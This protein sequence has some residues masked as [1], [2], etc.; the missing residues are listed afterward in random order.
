M[1]TLCTMLMAV[2]VVLVW[3]A[4]QVSACEGCGCKDKAK[5]E[6]AKAA[7]PA[8]AETAPK[9]VACPKAQAGTDGKA[10]VKCPGNCKEGCCKGDPAKCAACPAA[11]TCKAAQADGTAAKACP[12]AAGETKACGAAAGETKACGAAKAQ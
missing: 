8:A 6:A 5:V 3:S 4:S 10:A 11:K 9:C 7:A 12:A 1:K 2:A